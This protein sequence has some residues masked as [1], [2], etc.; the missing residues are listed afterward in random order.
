MDTGEDL[1]RVHKYGNRVLENKLLP[2]GNFDDGDKVKRVGPQ[3]LV[4]YGKF[5]SL[6][7]I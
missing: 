3:S 7:Y 1:Q 4:K 6:P 2:L 5:E